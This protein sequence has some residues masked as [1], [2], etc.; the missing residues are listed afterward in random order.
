MLDN[1]GSIS[2]SHR[3]HCERL[4]VIQHGHVERP[5]ALSSAD[6]ALFVLPGFPRSTVNDALSVVDAVIRC[7]DDG[8]D[9]PGE[10]QSGW[11]NYGSTVIVQQAA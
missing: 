8:S 7:L 10:V 11:V 4:T 1:C 2:D 5:L 9:G 3:T 6:I